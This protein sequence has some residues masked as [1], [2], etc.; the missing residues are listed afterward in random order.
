MSNNIQNHEQ[1]RCCHTLRRAALE[2]RAQV[3]AT[4]F[5][6]FRQSKYKIL[7]SAVI[8]DSPREPRNM[9]MSS[10]R[11]STFHDVKLG[12]T[13]NQRTSTY[14]GSCSLM[15]FFSAS[16]PDDHLVRLILVSHGGQ[17]TIYF[18]H[19]SCELTRHD[20]CSRCEMCC[21][22]KHQRLWPRRLEVWE[23]SAA[24]WDTC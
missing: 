12:R 4:E 15:L 14:N 6:T 5:Q 23:V 2:L 7:N 16:G 24:L 11:G 1:R 9:S 18:C 13:V 17:A 3:M 10:Q 21:T 20:Y 19:C 8:A 22:H